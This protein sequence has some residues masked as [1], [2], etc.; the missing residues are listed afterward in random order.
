MLGKFGKIMKRQSVGE[1]RIEKGIYQRGPCSFQVK[2]LFQGH[3]LNGTFDTLAEAR[4]FRDSK[5]AS[6]ALDPDAARVLKSRV[7]RNEIRTFT[8]EAALKPDYAGRDA[9]PRRGRGAYAGRVHV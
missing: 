5:R 4:A 8:L 2:M 1:R 7:R 3:P 9:T 6:L